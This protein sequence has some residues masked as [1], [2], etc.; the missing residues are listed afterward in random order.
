M[1]L[2]YLIV[3]MLVYNKQFIW[4]IHSVPAEIVYGGGRCDV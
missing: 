3:H 1:N 4:K 2:Q